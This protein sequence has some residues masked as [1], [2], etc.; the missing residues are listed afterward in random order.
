MLQQNTPVEIVNCGGHMV[1]VKRE[2][3]CI[4]GPSFSKLRGVAAHLRSRPEEVVGVLD[5]FHSRAGWGVSYLCQPGSQGIE[6]K[7]VVYYPVYKEDMII[8]GN[9]LAAKKCG[10]QIVGIEAG[11]SC[12]LYHR[13]K[14]DLATKFPNSYMLPNALKCV[15]SVEE[16]AAEVRTI[17][18][19]YLNKN[20][21]WVVSVSS[22][23]IAAGVLQ[24]LVQLNAK[25]NLILHEGY[26]RPEKA[27]L[28]YV[29][30]KAGGAGK[31][32][33]SVVDENYD[34]K[35]GVPQVVCPFPCNIYYDRKAWW[36]IMR[37][38]V[39]QQF[40]FWNVGA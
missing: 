21:T 33:I 37:Q 4:G 6:K 15:E 13:A 10:A 32:S 8:R 16:T 23:T 19:V 35:M 29:I 28:D 11:R 39:K 22:G 38:P 26:S 30:N 14:K 27:L 5:T 17:D 18:P 2:D 40:L 20:F 31:V 7:V 34:Y 1:H 9:Q 24:G 12:I 3:L 25:V 36:W